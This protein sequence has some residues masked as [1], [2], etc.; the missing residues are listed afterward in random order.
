MDSR[1]LLVQWAP[2]PVESRNGIIVEYVVN[3]SAQ[4]TA[5]QIQHGTTGDMSSLNIRGLH[6]YY[7]YTYTVAAGTGIGRGPF[8]TFHSIKM[9]EDGM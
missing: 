5:E 1:T 3:I 4:E 6:P 7:T 9:P 2:P 8:S